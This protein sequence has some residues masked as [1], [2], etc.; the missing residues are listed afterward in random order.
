MKIPLLNL[1]I[2]NDD[3]NFKKS[4]VN[5]YSG[6]KTSR[7]SK[8]QNSSSY[9][10]Y[11][12]RYYYIPKC[13]CLVSIH[14]YIKLFKKILSDIF[15]KVS[16]QKAQPFNI[17]LEK[18]ITNLIIEVPH[19]PR[20]LYSIEYTL[21]DNKFTLDNTQNNKILICPI[22]LKKII[23]NIKLNVILEVIKHILLGSKILFFSTSIN[24]LTDVILSFLYL[25]FPFK[26]P[27]QVTSFLSKHSYAILESISPFIVGINEQFE[28][29]FFEENEISLE[30]MSVYVVDLD[31]KTSKLYSDETFPNFPSKALLN[32]EKDIDY[33]ENKKKDKEVVENLNEEYQNI[34]FNFF[35]EIL[36]NYEEFLNMN[37]FNN[38]DN[39]IMT[40][41]ETLYLCDKFIN[42]HN[43]NDVEFYEKFVKD[44]QLFAD[45]IYKRMIP[46]NN[47]EIIDISLVNEK[48]SKQSKLNFLLKDHIDISKYKGYNIANKYTVLGAREISKEEKKSINEKMTDIINSGTILIKEKI[49]VLKSSKINIKEDTEKISFKYYLFPKL[50]FN[51]YCNNENVNEYYPPPDFSEEIEAINTDFV[52]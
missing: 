23:T 12:L 2:N 22:D 15:E 3:N 24:N 32:I 36:K 14:P 7:E 8:L 1:P 46:K 17:P 21:F 19:P 45:F 41:I 13:I 11:Q 6:N 16:D 42:G 25:I 49:K 52:S 29:K 47:Q 26:Y 35:C 4:I 43:A 40:S 10:S 44:S 50:F 48:C 34:F 33:I 30:G 28:E 51:I 18:Y 39:E 38:R 20:G 5:N 37:Y 31:N 9:P 27:F